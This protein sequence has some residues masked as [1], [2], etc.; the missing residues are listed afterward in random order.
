MGRPR[1]VTIFFVAML[2]IFGVAA[3]TAGIVVVGIE[4]RGRFRAPRLADRM[5][6][7]ARHLNGDEQRSH[8]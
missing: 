1:S 6:R 5:A 2:V 7:A 3:V 8:R 4:G